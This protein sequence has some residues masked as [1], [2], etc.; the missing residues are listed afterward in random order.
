MLYFTDLQLKMY[1][2]EGQCDRRSA[3]LLLSI[4]LLTKTALN[5]EYAPLTDLTAVET[6]LAGLA[7]FK[8][9]EDFESRVKPLVEGSFLL[10]EEFRVDN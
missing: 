1:L 9:L 10:L 3:R 5:L 4:V 7:S 8:A 6:K 2:L